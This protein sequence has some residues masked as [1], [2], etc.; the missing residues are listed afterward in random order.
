M[1]VSP[2][3]GW[4][5]DPTDGRRVLTEPFFLEL[6]GEER[7]L[8]EHFTFAPPLNGDRSAVEFPPGDGVPLDV[9]PRRHDLQGFTCFQVPAGRPGSGLAECE[10]VLP[11]DP[12]RPGGGT[13]H[14]TA[15]WLRPGTAAPRLLERPDRHA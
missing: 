15:G 1:P 4:T 3:G 5:P 12:A 11:G 13:Q 8:P 7:A 9:L 6:D 14:L 10:P 2:E